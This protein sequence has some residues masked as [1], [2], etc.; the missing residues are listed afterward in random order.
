ME[1]VYTIDQFYES[2][3]LG[4]MLEIARKSGIWNVVAYIPTYAD[5]TNLLVANG[6]I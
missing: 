3:T 4:K 1:V 6:F 2:S 5:E